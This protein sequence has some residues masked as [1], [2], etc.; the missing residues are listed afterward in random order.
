M[1][2]RA[3]VL[4]AF[5][6]TARFVIR[7]QLGAGGFGVVYHV[8][9]K[10]TKSEVAL[11]IL[12]QNDP[13]AIYQ[14]KQEFRVLANVVH[15]N[16]VAYYELLSEG[17]RWLIVMEL[18]DGVSFLDYIR[19]E[20]QSLTERSSGDD[21]TA[22]ITDAVNA[23][24]QT[25]GESESSPAAQ[26]AISGWAVTQT[27]ALQVRDTRAEPIIV[28]SSLG[29]WAMQRAVFSV[30]SERMRLAFVQL[31][32]GVRALHS[33]KILH[34]DLKP[35]NVLVHPSGR[36]MLLDFGLAKELLP[37]REQGGSTPAAKVSGTPAY[38][39]PEPL[40]GE[41]ETE[42]SDWYSFGV[43]LYEALSGRAPFSGSVAE[44]L[45]AKLDREPPP[46]SMIVD[47]VPSDLDS[48]CQALLRRRPEARP[49]ADEI[50]ERLRVAEHR[51]GAD[52]P[53]SSSPASLKSEIRPLVGRE[54]ERGA[55]MEAFEKSAAG[56]PVVA[57]IHGRSGIGKSSLV[58]NFLETLHRRNAAL[59]L[60]GRCYEREYLPFKAFDSLIDFLSAYLT[61]LPEAQAREILPKDIKD[62]ARLFPV[63]A[64]FAEI[65]QA[66]GRLLDTID[67]QQARM[68]GFRALKEIFGRIAARQ[69]LVLFIDDLQWGDMDSARLLLEILSAPDAPPLLLLACYRSDE[70]EESPFLGKV[71]QMLRSPLS[72]VTTYDI[73]VG[74]LSY[75]HS[76]AYALDCFGSRSSVTEKWAAKIAKESEGHP[77]FVEELVR[78]AQA[79]RPEGDGEPPSNP[80]VDV[81]LTEVIRKRLATLSK[82]SRRLLELAAVAGRPLE[83]RIA[84]S[85]EEL[86]ANP[87]ASLALL[88]A[89]NLLRARGVRD[90]VGIEVYHDRIRAAVVAELSP[91]DLAAY[92]RCLA[93]AFQ[94]E[95]EPDPEVLAVH[96]YGAGELE[97]AAMHAEAAAERADSALAFSHAAE[98][99]GLA[100]E[101][102]RGGSRDSPEA[103]RRLQTLR[104]GALAN[105]GRGGEAAPLYLLAAEGAP[106]AESRESLQKAAEQYLVSG[107]IDE[108]VKIL[109]PLLSSVRLRYPASTLKAMSIMM[110]LFLRLT[111]RGYRFSER[112]PSELEPDE[113]TRIDMCWAAGKGLADVDPLRSTCFQL[114]SLLTSLQIG[115]PRRIA[116]GC[117]MFGAMLLS[118]GTPKGLAKGAEV[119]SRAQ[120]IA[121]D[122]GDPHLLAF[123]R[124]SASFS[125]LVVGDWRGAL[126]HADGGLK[127]IQENCTGIAWECN[128]ARTIA[129]V[130]L[131]S[132]GR[133]RELSSR[134]AEW[135]RES[136][137]VGNL[138]AQITAAL[139]SAIAHIA[140][141]DPDMARQRV[142]EAIA[143]WSQRGFSVQHMYALR[144]EACADLYEG[145]PASAR[146][147]VWE[148][149]PVI[150]SSQLLRVQFGRVDMHLLRAKTAI[151]CAARGGPGREALLRT[152][153]R[154]AGQLEREIRRDSMPTARL[155]RAG[156][157]RVRGDRDAAAAHLSEAAS[158]FDACD[159]ALHAACCRR[160]RGELIGGDEGRDLIT[161][162]DALMRSQ[163]IKSPERWCAIYAPG[164]D[165]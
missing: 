115:E 73:P 141:D 165:L 145:D 55:L 52:A 61:G 18:V 21:P 36:V 146:S 158:A 108:G 163:D 48:L 44:V 104:A 97:A 5:A 130:P 156:I 85:D 4:Q 60:R 124:I 35:S 103:R 24:V 77:F 109:V 69:S 12:Y 70:V 121:R 39:A 154:D 132:M 90:Q 38:I 74:P 20:A 71:L 56:Q 7:R 23:P 136:V 157:A 101:W 8:H 92:H 94:A 43:M 110:F 1:N 19:N 96:Y 14:F 155:L 57:C 10:Q 140:A 164:F 126:E 89:T 33:S 151:A 138:F 42:A 119:I 59:I 37:Q 2:A 67:P 95:P 62:A 153:D 116:R 120:A 76:V 13:N 114:R 9:D 40:A 6:G 144:V 129:M 16:V 65:S 93:A 32:E 26:A 81:T 84:F 107:H 66:T 17:D 54:M 105:A 75:G 86:G 63:L 152:A 50:V 3:Q 147:R 46:P 162:A 135:Y 125:H 122:L 45:R 58:S 160:R 41:P 11:K 80:L 22:S 29:G 88:R 102:G 106:P 150:E 72:Q 117:C 161:G 25:I 139:S 127:Q 51:S 111:V 82:P 113:L 128:L 133:F 134:T 159:M 148:A 47:G 142:R 143:R 91:K 15:P 27:A 79:S 64:P 100:L 118:Q 30:G 83:Q 99:Y 98:L 49:S 131:E 53:R 68:R 78:Y 149:W 28:R 87:I 123:T 34:R 137:A 112:P 31:A